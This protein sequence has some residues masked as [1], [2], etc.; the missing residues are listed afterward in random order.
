M[1]INEAPPHMR[2]ISLSLTSR[3]PLPGTR[4]SSAGLP[5]SHAR[6]RQRQLTG[7]AAAQLVLD[8]YCAGS[9]T[10]ALEVDSIDH[11]LANFE[12]HDIIPE[13]IID[14]TAT[15]TDPPSKSNQDCGTSPP[16]L[17]ATREP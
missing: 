5:T 12:H 17:Q 8:P 4:R 7:D 1:T 11:G 6:F 14:G 16:G 9:S 15:I 2:S 13:S 3:P 10:V